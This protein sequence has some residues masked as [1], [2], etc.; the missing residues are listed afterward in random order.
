MPNPSELERDQP[1][2]R[3]NDRP[4]VWSLVIEDMRRRDHVGRQRY[5][6]PLQPH[7]GRDG[8]V[9]LYQE[10][11]DAAVYIRQEI[12]ERA[13]LRA[14][15]ERLRAGIR[16]HRDYCGDDRCHLDDGELY[17]LLPE[18]DTRPERDTAVTLANC[19]KFIECRQK[20]R[21]YVSPEREIER[22]REEKRQL[23]VENADLRELLKLAGR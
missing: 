9:D 21:E 11:L 20:G 15:V 5:G 3:P 10:I 8:L 7:N 22:L 12:E 23:F 1:D 14:E 17:A 16:R 18:G 4:A 13:D 2:P 19:V 6:T